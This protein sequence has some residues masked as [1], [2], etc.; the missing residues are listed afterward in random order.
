MRGRPIGGLRDRV[1][2]QSRGAPQNGYGE[3]VLAWATLATVW[4]RVEP[5]SGR[6]TWQAQQA[7][8]DVTHR[9]TVRTYPGLTSKMRFLLGGRVL[10]IDSVIDV[11]GRRQFQECLCKE[12]T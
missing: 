10:N 1:E 12:E 5:I 4:A 11:E 7:Q 2:I 3:P 9:V 8:A 6:E